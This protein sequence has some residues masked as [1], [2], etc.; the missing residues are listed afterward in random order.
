MS[1]PPIAVGRKTLTALAWVTD[2][3]GLKIASSGNPGP[4]EAPIQL[5][6][7]A[8]GELVRTIGPAA[9]DMIAI[10]Q[11]PDGKTVAFGGYSRN[12]YFWDVKNDR[13]RMVVAGDNGDFSASAS[14]SPDSKLIATNGWSND[15]RIVESG[16]RGIVARAPVTNADRTRGADWAH[17]GNRLAYPCADLVYIWSAL[18]SRHYATAEGG[19]HAAPDGLRA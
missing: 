14:W 10:E 9:N 11:S 6:N 19:R 7:P 17:V 3:S 4:G 1:L 16:L 15:H 5:W 8:G 18:E 13:E 12:I 2:K